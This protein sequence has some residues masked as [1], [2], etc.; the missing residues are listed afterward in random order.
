MPF[1]FSYNLKERRA[2]ISK[3]YINVEISLIVKKTIILCIFLRITLWYQICTFDRLNKLSIH[4]YIHTYRQ[5]DR[6]TDR[7]ACTYSCI[8][9][10]IYTFIFCLWIWKFILGPPIPPGEY[11]TWENRS[12]V[13]PECLPTLTKSKII[14]VQYYVK[15]KLKVRWGFDISLTLP[16]TIGKKRNQAENNNQPA[17]NNQPLPRKAIYIWLLFYWMT[18][19]S[20]YMNN[21]VLRY[22]IMRHV[23]TMQPATLCFIQRYYLKSWNDFPAFFSFY[24]KAA[25][26]LHTYP[27]R[28]QL[29]YPTMSH[30]QPYQVT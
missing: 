9:L 22:M 19:T 2:N 4:T 13:I 20:K 1:V 3:M 8:L 16:V 27:A 23:F 29:G 14:I 26:T 7:H 17:Y 28:S 11:A 12:F 30:T 21:E 5:T 25:P 18:P 10:C 24:E 15:V 6:Q